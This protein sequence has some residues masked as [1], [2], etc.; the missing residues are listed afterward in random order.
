MCKECNCYGAKHPYG[1]GGSAV[2]KPAKATAPVAKKM[3]METEYED[4]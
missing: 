4:D 1:V 3:E 2:Y